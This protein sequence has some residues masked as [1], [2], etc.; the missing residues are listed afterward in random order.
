MEPTVHTTP[1]TSKELVVITEQNVL[2]ALSAISIKEQTLAKAKELLN[3]KIAGLD[4]KEGYKKADDSR[5][6]VRKL[7]LDVQKRSKDI[8]DQVNDFKRKLDDETTRITGIL[9]QAEEH[10]RSEI[11]RID[12]EKEAIKQR[13]AQRRQKLLLDAGFR[14]NGTFFIAGEVILAPEK[15]INYSDEELEQHLE[16]GKRE[17]AR[18]AAEQAELAR[19]KAEAEAKA[20]AEQEAAAKELELEKLRKKASIDY[21]PTEA[22]LAQK[23]K[24]AK[25]EEFLEQAKQD[26]APALPESQKYEQLVGR[27]QRQPQ[28]GLAHTSAP[29]PFEIG[30]RT[31]ISAVIFLLN[32][33][34]KMTR[35]ELIERI[36]GLKPEDHTKPF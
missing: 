21:D 6:K 2:D 30:F 8:K 14:W 5:A 16:A 7:R 1:E 23:A 22:L 10:L 4:D 35:A 18:I 24:L 15:L 3:F 12:A 31:A 28:P 29:T 17:V 26:I 11:G 27:G 25:T 9:G 19:L 33:P 32:T 36:R 20:R 34:E 13:E